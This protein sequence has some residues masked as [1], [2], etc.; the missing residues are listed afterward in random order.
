MPGTAEKSLDAL[1]AVRASGSKVSLYQRCR[2]ARRCLG[3]HSPASG[4]RRSYFVTPRLASSDTSAEALVSGVA[5]AIL[6]ASSSS[7]CTITEP[8]MNTDDDSS[9]E[10][11]AG[12]PSKAG[13]I[14]RLQA[15]G[16]VNRNIDSI[17]NLRIGC[18]LVEQIAHKV[19]NKNP[20]LKG[21][22]LNYIYVVAKT[23]QSKPLGQI[24]TAGH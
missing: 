12:L 20:P 9:C 23:L 11:E 3:S 10:P 21:R 7:S 13:S 18:N 8:G 15:R 17:N 1:V 14:L 4:K 19:T 24:R 2:P 22:V 16:S 5:S 6:S